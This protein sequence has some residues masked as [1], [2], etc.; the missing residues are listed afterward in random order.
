MGTELSRMREE[1]LR[2]GAQS[3]AQ[4]SSEDAEA[5]KSS[6]KEAVVEGLCVLVLRVLSDLGHPWRVT[7]GARG[8]RLLFDR[9]P[10]LASPTG[11]GL[12]CVCAGVRGELLLWV[13]RSLELPQVERGIG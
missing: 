8:L 6:W 9:L 3:R 10:C 7:R 2:S 5:Q 12:V 13:P 1:L 4:S 11:M